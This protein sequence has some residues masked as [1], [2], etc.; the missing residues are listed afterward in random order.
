ML[1]KLIHR[2]ALTMS[3]VSFETMCLGEGLLTVALIEDDGRF[4]LS[5]THRPS[6]YCVLGF[7]PAD[8][9]GLGDAIAARDE[10]LAVFDWSNVPDS[11]DAEGGAELNKVVVPIRE[12]YKTKTLAWQDHINASL[13]FDCDAPDED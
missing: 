3:H 11:P 13:G 9:E 6:G 10:L 7:L 2:V 8:D 1:E 12:K 4:G 5:I